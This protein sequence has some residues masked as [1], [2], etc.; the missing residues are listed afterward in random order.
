[1]AHC[2]P[3]ST[4]RGPYLIMPAEFPRRREWQLAVISAANLRTSATTDRGQ[5]TRAE[6]ALIALAREEI[7]HFRDSGDPQK[8]H[9][10]TSQLDR[11]MALR[12]NRSYWFPVAAADRERAKEQHAYRESSRRQLTLTQMASSDRH[13]RLRLELQEDAARD[14]ADPQEIFWK[15]MTKLSGTSTPWISVEEIMRVYP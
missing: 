11:H 8:V 9:L 10:W 1:M 7:R 2:R 5:R 4:R 13:D 14:N 3:L 12:A 6:E 15:A